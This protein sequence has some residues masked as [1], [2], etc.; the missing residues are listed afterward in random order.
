MWR[1]RIGRITRSIA[2]R[3][4]M[5]KIVM[6]ILTPGRRTRTERRR[7]RKAS[8]F[9]FRTPSTHQ[10]KNPSNLT[11]DRSTSI[12]KYNTFRALTTNQPPCT[13]NQ[14]ALTIQSLFSHNTPPKNSKTEIPPLARSNLF[15]T[16]VHSTPQHKKTSQEQVAK[17]TN[18][19]PPDSNCLHPTTSGNRYQ[20]PVFF[21]T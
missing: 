16:Q 11:N 7:L 19:G 12:P 4:S 20:D 15:P 9:F 1:G 2:V 14:I 17:H 8:S 3:S 5:R 21:C 18:G 10:S 13:Q 6:M